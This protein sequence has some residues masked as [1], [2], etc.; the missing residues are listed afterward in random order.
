MTT[1][2]NG[3][4]RGIGDRCSCAAACQWHSGTAHSAR[5]HPSTSS[6]WKTSLQSSLAYFVLLSSCACL[7][8]L[9]RPVS[10]M[11][12]APTPDA[13]LELAAFTQ[14]CV[15]P[16]QVSIHMYAEFKEHQ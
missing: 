12:D 6:V 7:G 3:D 8:D 15:K 10:F 1:I 5:T 13:Q 9:P 2:A 14:V 11:I 16:G 4:S